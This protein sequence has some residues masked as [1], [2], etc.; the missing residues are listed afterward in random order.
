MDS[1]G[2]RAGAAFESIVLAPIVRSMFPEADVLGN[3]GATLLAGEI[4]E[5]DSA[6]SRAIAAALPSP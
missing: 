6:F 5:R 2:L 1:S 3:Y 4:A